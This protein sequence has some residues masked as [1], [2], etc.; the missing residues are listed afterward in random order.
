MKPIVNLEESPGRIVGRRQ[1]VDYDRLVANARAIMPRLPFPKGVYRFRSHEEG[2]EW[3]SQH[4]LRAAR[5]EPHA[6]PNK[7]T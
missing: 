4:I 5:N 1:G 3:M 2:D 7:A 6:P